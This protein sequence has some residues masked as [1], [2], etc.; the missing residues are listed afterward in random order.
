MVAGVAKGIANH[1]GIADWIPRIVFV[2]TAFMGGLGLALYAAG[3]AFIRGEDEAQSPVERITS[4]SSGPRSWVG[5]ILI[6][7]GAVVILDV[8]TVLDGQVVWATALLVAGMLLYLGY[9]NP[10]GGSA[11]PP[12]NSEDS[13]DEPNPVETTPPA[14]AAA[15]SPPALTPP[16]LPTPPDLPPR[17]PKEPSILGRITLGVMLLGLGIL[18]VLD[19]IESLPIDADPRHYLALAVTIL[20]LG[21][22][23]GSVI[24]RARWLIV[25]GVLTIPSLIFSPIFEYD[26]NGEAF[27]V[28]VHPT[29]FAELEPSYATEVGNMVVDLTDLD[30]SGQTVELTATVDVGNLEVR[31]P[32]GVA[33][34]GEARADIGRVAG[35]DPGHESFGFDDPVVGLD[36]PGSRGTLVLFAE[37]GAGNIEVEYR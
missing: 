31:I 20:G 9:V 8:L 15:V 7:L 17:Q 6:A 24:G 1:L 12:P 19:N 10:R 5:L 22:I 13:T 4:R 11:G 33:L 26:W 29:T 2:V 36:T 35:P 21:L 27:D 34:Q 30:W 16:L 18:A 28:V 32:E 23:V 14:A 37:V 25:L 3:W